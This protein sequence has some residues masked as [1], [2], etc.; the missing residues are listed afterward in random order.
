VPSSLTK[1]K[2][3]W[4]WNAGEEGTAKLRVHVE[5][6][7]DAE[8]SATL[9]E[10]VAEGAL[11]MLAAAL[12]AEVEAYVTSLIDE[13][14]EEGHRLVVRNGHAVP[15][16]LVTGAGPIE[17]RAPRVDDRRVDEVTGEKM[18][19]R[20]AILPPWARKS[21]KVADVLPL[22][23]LHGMSSG[24]FVPTLEEF[25]GSVAG[26][27]AS[28]VTRLSTEW[29]K[30]QERFAHRSLKDVDYIY[31]YADGQQQPFVWSQHDGPTILPAYS[32]EYANGV[33]ASAQALNDW[34]DIVGWSVRANGTGADALVWQIPV[35]HG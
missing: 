22:M 19:F 35:T 8:L 14:D 20:S 10:L 16:S 5:E 7:A 32:D 2:R 25:F 28:V 30:E 24:D 6:S 15:R 18:R 4:R 13:R 9:D 21:P 11:R 33:V 17:V 23:Y 12:E 26:L 29:Q 31:V 34:G 1:S 3:R 27:S